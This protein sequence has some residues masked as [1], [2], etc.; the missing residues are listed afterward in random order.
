MSNPTLHPAILLSPVENGYVAYDPIGDRLH[1]LNPV[2]ALIAELCDGTK[3]VE[4]IRE[5]VGPLLPEGKAAEVDRW[6]TEG[7]EAG[8]LAWSGGAVDGQRELTASEL[9][10]LA[11]RLRQNGKTQT[12]FLCQQRAAELA[13][14]DS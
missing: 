12:A 9:S 10:D 2:A 7:M 11:Q 8:L 13:A 5:I 14:D 6:I 3:N 1:E 4:E